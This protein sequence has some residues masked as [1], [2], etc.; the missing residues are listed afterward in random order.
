MTPFELSHVKGTTEND[1]ID[2]GSS[3]TVHKLLFSANTKCMTF[4]SLMSTQTNE[5]K[6][7][8]AQV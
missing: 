5:N 3:M 6:C 4:V 1:N 8:F 2:D 7:C